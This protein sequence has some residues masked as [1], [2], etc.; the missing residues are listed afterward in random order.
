MKVTV[1]IPATGLTDVYFKSTDGKTYQMH[2]SKSAWNTNTLVLDPGNLQLNGKIVTET[3]ETVSDVLP[4]L[5]DLDIAPP[6]AAEI[7]RQIRA[8]EGIEKVQI[9][10]L[11]NVEREHDSLGLPKVEALRKLL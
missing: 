3:N 6:S 11:E 1:N 9:N 7:S 5:N 4:S 10:S 8:K 2:L